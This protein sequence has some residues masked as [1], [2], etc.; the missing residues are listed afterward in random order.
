MCQI[1][2]IKTVCEKIF[3][4][5]REWMQGISH[6]SGPDTSLFHDSVFNLVLT[7]PVDNI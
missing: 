7:S 6:A 4:L 3:I 2:Y 1:A 5:R